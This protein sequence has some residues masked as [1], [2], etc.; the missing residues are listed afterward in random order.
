M[1]N[2]LI[3]ISLII[4]ICTG[5][6]N[7]DPLAEI[8]KLANSQEIQE[9][10]EAAEQYKI[11]IDTL[12]EAYRSLGGLNK[13]IG[14]KLMINK[15]YKEAIKHFEIAKD[16]RNDDPNIYFWLG[17]CYVNL[18]KVEGNKEYLV[19]AEKSYKIALIIKPEQMDILYGYAHLL[20]Y[21]K[22][23]YNEALNVLKKYM[24]LKPFLSKPDLNAYFLLGRIYYLLEDYKSS[25][26]TYNKIY[27][28]KNNLTKDQKNKL[29]EFI[30]ET[31]RKM[32]GE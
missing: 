11:A 5:C 9:K 28:Y 24:E 16:I 13:A 31:G 27:E 3:L 30:I 17:V 32:Q 1:K 8:R 19:E 22:N 29:D 14:E 15:S 12:V 25:Y 18:Y 4:L 6:I 10:Q 2:Y 20:V 26:E 21:G 7:R 23:D